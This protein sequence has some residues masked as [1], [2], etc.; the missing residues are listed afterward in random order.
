[1]DGEIINADAL[2]VYS[3]INILSARPDVT[4]R[5]GVPHHLFGHVSGKTLYSTGD[6]LR[7]TLRVL[8]G[9]DGRGKTS[10]LVGGTGLYFQALLQGLADIP[11][12]DEGVQKD[13]EKLSVDA[14]RQEAEQI[15][16]IAA[17]RVLGNDPQRLGRIVGVFR[18]TGK[19]LS[20]WQ[21]DT[22][23]SVSATKTHRAVLLPERETLYQRINL[24][25]DMMIEA[26]A[27]EEACSVKE[28]HYPD[29]APMLKAIGLS[30]LL[31]HL[32]GECDLDDA[33]EI[34][35]RDSRRLA[36]R[37][38]TWFRNRCSDWDALLTRSDMDKYL[39]TL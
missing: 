6:W 19:A 37:Q 29:R 30:H 21:T 11:D 2:Q 13:V 18:S 10:I 7:D 15:D 14:L 22:Q 38:M 20:D 12:I 33:I 8:A 31:S 5:A 27:L 24:R 39:K 32:D 4:E 25:F 3:D 36:K 34:A 28:R 35:K 26:G 16:P 1:M 9:I 17:G 23:S